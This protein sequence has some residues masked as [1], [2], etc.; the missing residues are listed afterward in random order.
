MVTMLMVTS[1]GLRVGHHPGEIR[2]HDL[3]PDRRLLMSPFW[4]NTH[5]VAVHLL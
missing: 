2:C 4:Q 5:R 1:A 3:A